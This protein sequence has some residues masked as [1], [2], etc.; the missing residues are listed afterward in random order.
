[1]P[2]FWVTDETKVH[3]SVNLGPLLDFKL[4]QFVNMPDR[5]RPEATGED[6]SEGAREAASFLMGHAAVL[7]PRATAQWQ[8]PRSLPSRLPSRLQSRLRPCWLCSRGERKVSGSGRPRSQAL[9]GLQGSCQENL[10]ETPQDPKGA[11]HRVIGVPGIHLHVCTTKRTP[12]CKPDG[13]FS[14]PAAPNQA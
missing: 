14:S 8:S 12:R 13:S 4:G 6:Q 9:W 2:G 1:M 10:S 3:S 7:Y 5:S 11:G